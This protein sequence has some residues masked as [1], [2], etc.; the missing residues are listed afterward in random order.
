MTEPLLQQTE[1]KAVIDIG[2]NSVRLVVFSGLSRV[3]DVIFN[4]KIMCGLGAEVGT[5]GAMG[6]DAMELA[7]TALKRYRHLCEQMGVVD[8]DTIATAAA[9][10]ADNGAD[11]VRR[12]QDEA[13]LD[14][15]I[16]SGDE[17]GRLAGL[18]VLAGQ[19]NA[20][21]IM[22]DLGGGSLE[23]ARMK[24]GTIH[25][26]V[27]LPIGPLRLRAAYGNHLPSIKK[28]IQAAFEKVEWLDKASSE[29][30]Y[31]VG[32]AWRNICKLMLWERANNLTILHGYKIP[33]RE[34]TTYCRRLVSLNPDDIPFANNL[35]SKRRDVL[36]IAALILSE[37]VKFLRAKHATVSTYGIREGFVFDQLN[38]DERGK[39]PFLYSCRV[40]AE[41]RCRFPEHADVIYDW[42]RPLFEKPVFLS[43]QMERLHMAICLLSDIAWRGHPD[44]RA[45]KAVELVL[46]G[47]FVSITHKERAFV[48][49]A[50][51]Q[52]YG[53]P[54]EA[55]Q[56][57]RI[58]SLLSIP[59]IMEARIMGS[60][61]R[62]AQRLS[63]GAV[64]GLE[65]SSMELSKRTVYLAISHKN[66]EILSSV[67]EK[68][69]KQLAI[70]M[71]KTPMI[72]VD[73]DLCDLSK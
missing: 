38:E 40:L 13:G 17:E 55:L 5:T 69:F 30:I 47:N 68:R 51:N 18:G 9:R 64:F 3:P 8:I 50:L 65:N 26:T 56:S 24:S 16:I 15:K 60:A 43:N 49:V 59:E 34:L 70:L 1:Y 23:L 67:V 12:V 54:I 58:L 20:T 63:G 44:F 72:K 66:K 33:H 42:T 6:E 14:V 32:G 21:G 28:H 52:A 48:A 53:A 41:E 11:F 25:E 61:I 45:E 10:D 2:S 46:H 62:L 71:G 57:T 4:E 36:P 31:L 22:G 37:L 19:P 39:D 27:S 73:N 35:P 7:V 29:D